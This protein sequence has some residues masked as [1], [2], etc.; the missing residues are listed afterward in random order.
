[1]VWQDNGSL[2]VVRRVTTREAAKSNF[3]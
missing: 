3:S 1:M 2:D